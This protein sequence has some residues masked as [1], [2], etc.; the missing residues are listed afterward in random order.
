MGKID[1]VITWVDGSDPR[2]AAKK[3]QYKNKKSAGSSEEKISEDKEK[4]R[5]RDWG[6]LPFLFRGIEQYAPWVNRVYL[7]TDEQAPAWLNREC[8]KLTLVDHKDFIP[9]EYLPAFS[10]NVIELNLHRIKGLSEQFVFFNDDMFLMNPCREEDFFKNGTPCDEGSLNGINGRDELFAGILFQD[11]SLMNRHYSSRDIKKNLGKW[12][13]LKYGTNIIRTMLLLPFNRL[14][15]IFNHHGPLPLKKSTYRKVWE[16]DGSILAETCTRKF[17]TA[18]DVSGYV[19]R[20]E[21]LLSGE[22]VP[23]KSLNRYLEVTSSVKE[24]DKAMKKFKTVCINDGEIEDDFFEQRK[25]EL[26]ALFLKKFPQKS[27][28]EKS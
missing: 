11:M 3:N 2:W 4:V 10:A 24:I 12:L 15:G 27:M 22:F 18:Q 17:R 5:Y 16:R 28:F 20:Y 1:F 8:P 6:L 7:V 21:Q 9:G 25:E 26:Q 13:N 23:Q 14:Q 19:F